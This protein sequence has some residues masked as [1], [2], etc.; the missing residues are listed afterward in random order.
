M[1]RRPLPLRKNRLFSIRFLVRHVIRHPSQRG[2][3]R[4]DVSAGCGVRRRDGWHFRL[5]NLWPST[6]GLF[7]RQ[8][9]TISFEN[10]SELTYGIILTN[11]GIAFAFALPRFTQLKC[12]HKRKCKQKEMTFFLFLASA[13]G[14]PLGFL[15]PFHTQPKKTLGTGLIY[16]CCVELR[17]GCCVVL[18]SLSSDVFE[19]RTSTGSEVFSLLTC[20]DDIKFVFLS[21]FT[22]IEAIW[23]KIWAKPPSKN[24]KRSL[25]VD[26][27]HSKRLL[28][29][30]PI[31]F[32]FTQG[33][34]STQKT[35]TPEIHGTLSTLYFCSVFCT[36]FH[37]ISEE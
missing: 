13:L 9:N 4:D 23:L 24:E 35:K 12:K 34:G 3:E 16:T 28:L 25:P 30:L 22:V 15:F 33:P 29:K 6:N 1:H 32:A 11:F 26:V 37:E 8:L 17:Y 31:V 19:R 18:G 2:G 21:F 14:C 7:S 36:S 27:R 5:F 20:L 10:D